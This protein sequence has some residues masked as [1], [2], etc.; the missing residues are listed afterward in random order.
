MKPDVDK[1]EAYIARQMEKQNIPGL[2]ITLSNGD[3]V[4]LSG[5]YGYIDESRSVQPDGDTV[6]GIASLSKSLTA[7]LTALLAAEGRL[8]LF[9]PVVKYFPSFAIPGVPR[10]AP[11]LIHLLTHS[12]GLPPLPLLEYSWAANT[13]RDPGEVWDTDAL[14]SFPPV[15]TVDEIVDYIREG[16][17]RPLGQPGEFFCY[18]NESYALLSSIIDMVTGMPMEEYMRVRLFEPLNMSRTSYDL[19]ALSASGN[20]TTLFSKN[21]DGSLRHSDNWSC[22]PPYRGCGWILSTSNDMN[23]Y[24]SMLSNGGRYRGRQIVGG[25]AAYYILGDYFPA[26]QEGPYALGL[27]KSAYH[28]V[29]LFA[30]NGGLKGVSSTG[31]FVKDSG[32][33]CCVLTNIGGVSAAGAFNAAINSC[34]GLPLDTPRNRYDLADSPCECAASF[35][36]RYGN[37]EDG[38]PLSYKPTRICVGADGLLVATVEGEDS[39]PVK[40][41]YCREN[42]FL[43]AEEGENP[44]GGTVY[45][46]FVRDGQVWGLGIS[47]RIYYRI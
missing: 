30:H 28:G 8:S 41:H 34:L 43:G 24:Y 4:I 26:R 38:M 1:L 10:N 7:T 22:C 2:S 17:Y 13:V 32:I 5:G 31:G 14:T 39:P 33:S 16:D 11:L 45:R 46:F 47:S 12:L 37:L 18:S 25:E 35:A 42:I 9:D 29:T 20:V 19:A 3:G 40:L 36:G 44:L 27:E 23:N 21:P 15:R 6:M